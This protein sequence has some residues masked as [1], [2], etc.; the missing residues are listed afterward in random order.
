M[1]IVDDMRKKIEE[2]EANIAVYEDISSNLPSDINYIV[3]SL[4]NHQLNDLRFRLERFTF[5][6]SEKQCSQCQNWIKEH[7]EPVL[8]N[9]QYNKMKPLHMTLCTNC[10]SAMDK[11]MV[12]N[13]A[14]SK[15]GLRPGTI[16]QDRHLG[17]LREFEDMGLIVN[18][19]RYIKVHELVMR[20]YYEPKQLE[21]AAKKD[22]KTKKTKNEKEAPQE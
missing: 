11:V 14:E 21:K 2:L 15:W 17:K 12:T 20:A 1:A 5:L 7:E 13:E 3:Q 9:Y 4:L 22:R 10:M 6:K 8:L 16:K 18:S 19:G